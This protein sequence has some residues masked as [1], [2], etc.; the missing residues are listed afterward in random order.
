[1]WYQW[2]DVVPAVR[3][4]ES[5]LLKAPSHVRQVFF[6]SGFATLT[7]L[8]NATTCSLLLKYLG[9]TKTPEAGVMGP[10]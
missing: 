5:L 9:L 1:M 3:C 8:V 7:L 6:V 10:L 4:A 2:L